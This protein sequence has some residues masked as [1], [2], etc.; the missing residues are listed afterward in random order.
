MHKNSK[1]MLS[2]VTIVLALFAL[3]MHWYMTR[4]SLNGFA[5]SIL[6][7]YNPEEANF[8]FGQSIRWT[9]A[10]KAAQ[11]NTLKAAINRLNESTFLVFRD[12]FD[13]YF[14]DSMIGSSMI[15]A[16]GYSMLMGILYILQKCFRVSN[17]DSCL[18]WCVQFLLNTILMVLL[19]TISI[20]ILSPIVQSGYTLIACTLLKLHIYLLT[21]NS[22]PFQIVYWIT[23][24]IAGFTI[25]LLFVFKER[26]VIYLHIFVYM[27]SGA[28]LSP[29]MNILY[30]VTA[31]FLTQ[32]ITEFDTLV[33]NESS[34]NDSLLMFFTVMCFLIAILAF[35]LCKLCGWLSGII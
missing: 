29:I 33:L 31:F 18:L 32:A 1:L 14:S 7:E 21:L 27:R 8:S 25:A 24:F 4:H 9:A 11:T 28:E 17:K 3:S 13:F 12:A 2:V 22:L 23:T 6:S 20:R 35:L 26:D 30:L 10:Q 34:E 16:I 19:Y 15:Y 5:N